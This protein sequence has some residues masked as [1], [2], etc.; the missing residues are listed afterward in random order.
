MH[1]LP[2]LLGATVVAAASAT[3]AGCAGAPA[4]PTASVV[5]RVAPSAQPVDLE[6]QLSQAHGDYREVRR[7]RSGETRRF[8]VPAGW[9]TVRVPG[10][11]VV[12][13]RNHGTAVVE[14][15]RHDCRLV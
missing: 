3:L 7:M 15:D 10:L 9:V 2:R 1:R 12:P 5:V 14:V 4:T 8:A 11:C 6:V 13:A